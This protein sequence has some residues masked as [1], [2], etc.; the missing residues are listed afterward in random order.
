MTNTPKQH[1]SAHKKSMYIGIFTILSVVFI[2][3]GIAFVMGVPTPSFTHADTFGD[4]TD[5]IP[6]NFDPSTIS[7]ISV[8]DSIPGL[9]DLTTGSNLSGDLGSI[10]SGI[11]AGI[12][13]GDIGGALGSNGGITGVDTGATPPEQ[14]DVPPCDN[15]GSASSGDSVDTGATPPIQVDVPPC[16][17]CGGTIPDAGPTPPTQVDVPPCDSCGGDSTPPIQVDVPPCD[18]C[19]G[20]TVPPETPPIEIPPVVIPPV[21]IPPVTPVCAEGQ[22]G[23]YP[24]C[25]TP[26]PPPPAQPECIS[27]TGTPTQIS[28]GD[29]VT[30]AWQTQNATSITIDN[31]VGSVTPVAAGSTIVHPTTSTTY[32]ATVAN[33]AGSVHCQTSVQV[34]TTPPPPPG[35]S[36]VQLTANATTIAPGQ[37]VTL[38]WV[39]SNATAISIDNGIGNV[40]PVASGSTTVTPSGTTTYTATVPGAAL[41]TACQ[42]TITVQ[43]TGCTSNCG[44]GGGG[45]GGGGIIFSGGGFGGG[46]SGQIIQP[47][48]Q[49]APVASMVYLSQI[50]YTGLDLGPVGTVVYWVLL[51]LICAVATY[52]ILFMLIPF[53]YHRIHNFGT[54]VNGMLNGTDTG[55]GAHG[56]H[57]AHATP[58]APVHAAAPVHHVPATNHAPNPSAYAAAE[59]FRTFA[60]GESLTIDDIV[61]GLSRIPEVQHTQAAPNTVTHTETH[62]VQDHV[63]EE[64]ATY[65]TAS[66]VIASHAPVHAPSHMPTNR[67]E[68]PAATISTDVRDFCDALLKGDRDTVFGTLRQ[69]VREGG[70][71]ETFITQVVCALDD[72]YRNRVDGTKV[73]PEIAQ[74]TKNCATSFLERLTGAL[75]NAVDSSYSPGI[76]GSKL[77]LTRALAVVEG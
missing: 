24:D 33:A 16:D 7:D 50:P 25:H 27:L 53:V 13:S 57:D 70:D 37:S 28:A 15:C 1:M 36:C 21:V 59:G 72:A 10:M 64:P 63:A 48:L 29:A 26:P 5:I 3:A 44:G 74:L 9:S 54:T 35:P 39:T 46:V 76:T 42:V 38:S 23:T 65:H 56:A 14:V 43:S 2:G 4:S 20:S 11:G 47:I 61:K 49:S 77:A 17:S 22:T 40:T 30:L 31:G 45:G 60:Q 18:N 52:L 8:S 58:A 12:G 68:A 62:I 34:V 71:A 75:T 69:I 6:I 66:E 67:A 55:H 51:L 32:I 73:N 41:N 19:G